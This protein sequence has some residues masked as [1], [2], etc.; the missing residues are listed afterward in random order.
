MKPYSEDLRTK[1][2]QALHRGMNKSE[3]ARTFGVSL[4]SVKRYA[5]MATNGESLA[6]KKPP[7]KTL[8]LDE[9]ARRLLEADLEERPTATLSQRREYLRLIAGVEVSISTVSRMINERLSWS[10][11]K[12]GR[13]ILLDP[14]HDLL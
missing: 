3:A 13:Q 2:V 10:R 7:G 5:K 6:P 12:L 4:S 8:K 11:K 14:G 1:I 9:S